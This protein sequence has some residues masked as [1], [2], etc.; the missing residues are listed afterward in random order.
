MSLENK[1]IELAIF[2]AFVISCI[3]LIPNVLIKRELDN[4]GLSYHPITLMVEEDEARL[5]APMIKISSFSIWPGD[6]LLSN[7]DKPLLWPPLP[8]AILGFANRFVDIETLRILIN[9]FVP[10]IIFIILYTIFTYLGG[11]TIITLGSSLVL[12]VTGY[13]ATLLPFSNLSQLNQFIALFNPFV[14]RPVLHHLFMDRI[15]SPEITFVPLALFILLFILGLVKE[16]RFWGVSA[17]LTFGLLFYTYFYD[18][19]TITIILAVF[20]LI[21][22]F[23]REW[24]LVRFGLKVFVIGL[25]GSFYYWITFFRLSVLPQFMELKLRVG[26]LEVGHFLRYQGLELHYLLW[27]ILSYLIYKRSEKK[28][29]PKLLF[30]MA[31]FLGA[32]IVHNVQ[33]VT[34][35]VPEAGHFL[36]FTLAIPLFIAYFICLKFTWDNY[37]IS[38]IKLKPI[39]YATFIIGVVLVITHTVSAQIGFAR[40]SAQ[41]YT[42]PAHMEAP[43]VWAKKEFGPTDTYITN[44]TVSNIYLSLLTPGRGY[45][46]PSGLSSLVSDSELIE[47]LV[48]THKYFGKSDDDVMELFSEPYLVNPK[49][50]EQKSV[51]ILLN[52]V[53]FRNEDIKKVQ[54]LANEALANRRLLGDIALNK[55][56]FNYVYIGPNEYS[57]ST[58][59]S[60]VLLKVCLVPVYSDKETKIYR[61]C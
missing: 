42:I 60:D 61:R 40:D 35:Y 26:D 54:K 18:W 21:T 49:D 56:K 16:G 48:F 41:R 45:Y 39:I 57:V 34:G 9:A 15:F 6:Y 27:L 14:Q 8:T 52:K 59:S 3:F 12:T 7:S 32:I 4:G 19:V 33:I 50:I 5:Y 23:Y 46:P 53:S 1:R 2:G 51:K 37:V 28:R 30:A 58:S 47:R 17:G 11:N 25:L 36:R 38:L 20:I 24:K 10:S 43:I 31:I 44:S 55:Y 13:I 22:L 29:D